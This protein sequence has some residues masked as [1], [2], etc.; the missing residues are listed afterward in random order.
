MRPAFEIIIEARKQARARGCF[1]VTKPNYW[2][3]YRV[4]SP[5]NQLVGKRSTPESLLE[6]AKV[7]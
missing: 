3:I 5:K 2:L 6:L 7:C 1:V 4:V